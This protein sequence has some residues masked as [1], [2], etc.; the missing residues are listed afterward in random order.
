[1]FEGQENGCASSIPTSSGIDAGDQE[2]IKD[3]I[4]STF[5]DLSSNISSDIKP[6]ISDLKCNLLEEH[7]AALSS[8]LR[9]VSRKS[10]QGQ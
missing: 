1:M 6:S 2:A 4:S 7:E 8:S 3:A 10:S 5:S 9:R